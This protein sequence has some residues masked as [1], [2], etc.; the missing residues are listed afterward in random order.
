MKGY[1]CGGKGPEEGDCSSGGGG[2]VRLGG[3]KGCIVTT[4]ENKTGTPGRR[5]WRQLPP[6]YVLRHTECCKSSPPTKSLG[7]RL[8]ADQM[9]HKLAHVWTY[10]GILQDIT[11]GDDHTYSM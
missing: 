2:R 11:H 9:S 7:T 10:I 5:K 3:V 1:R 6:A 8:T 4:V